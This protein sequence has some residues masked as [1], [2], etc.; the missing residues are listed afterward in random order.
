MIETNV[1]D[2]A[3]NLIAPL[4]EDLME[5]GALDVSVTST[6]M[7]K[8]RP[9]HLIT[10]VSPPELAA[11]LVDH[12]LRHSTTLGGRMTRAQ[13]GIAARRS[14]EVRTAPVVTRVTV[15]EVECRRSAL[16]P[17]Y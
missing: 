4:C 6:L 1:D 10:V 12:L 9:G 3:P 7:K 11:Q 17:G 2:M 5:A 16:S 13:R 15:K 14:I 8:G